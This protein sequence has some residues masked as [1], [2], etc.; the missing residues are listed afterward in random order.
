MRALL[1]GL[2][3]LTLLAIATP[4]A[5]QSMAGG[6]WAFG[7]GAGTDNRSKDVSKSGTDAYGW[8]LTEWTS[9]DGFF[10]GGAGAETI[11]SSGSN[12]EIEAGFGIRPQMGGFD[13]DLNA[14][15]KWRVDANP[16][17]DDD[18]WEFTA[19]VSR[20]IGPAKAKLRLQYSP[21]GTGSTEAWTWV[22]A[23]ASWDL[24]LDTALSAGIGRREQ[25]LSV[26]YTGW[27]VGVTWQLAPAVDLDLRYHDTDADP[28][29]FGDQYGS[30]LVANVGF[31]F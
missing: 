28:T 3:A 2:S 30:A 13:F 18:A 21:D 29:L 17:T 24:T 7:V 15:H 1:T 6:D 5:A 8:A 31:Y 11:D 26:D 10:Y 4:A 16:G 23:R 22:E 12:L 20:A 9:G 14:T 25:D 27:D 19:D